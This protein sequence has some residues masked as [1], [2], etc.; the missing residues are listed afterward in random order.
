MGVSLF[1]SRVILGVLGIDDYGIYN[2][3]GGMVAMFS[4]FSTSLS[5]AISRFITFTIGK[6]ETWRLAAIFSTSIFIQL[7]LSIALA[8]ILET[9]G[10]YFFSERLNIPIDRMESAI[11]TFHCS[12]LIFILSIISVPYKATIIAYEKM[13]AFAYIGIVEVVMKLAI[14]YLLYIADYDKLKTYSILLVF[15]SIIILGINILY[16]K[17]HFSECKISRC[18][19][20]SIAKEMF[21]FAGW[22]IMGTSAYLI[23]TQGVNVLTNI[24]FGVTANAARGIANQVNAAVMQFVNSFTTAINPQITKSYA[25]GDLDYMFKLICKGAKLSFFM[26]Y[27]FTLPFMFE[28]EFILELWLKNYPSYAPLFLRLVLVDQMIDFLGNTTARAVWA[29][30]NVKKYYLK[31]SMISLLVL[32]ISYLM[33]YLGFSPEVPYYIFLTIYLIL[34]PVRLGVLNRLVRKFEPTFY[35]KQVIVPVLYV[36]VSS[37]ILPFVFYY[38]LNDGLWKHLLM[39][40]ISCFSVTFITYSL[41]LSMGEKIYIRKKIYSLIH[42]N[43]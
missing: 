6:G 34:I 4:F 36:S 10:F 8:L 3:V 35:Y 28:A 39:I 9:L 22:N 33:F 18:F 7:I 42:R 27:F 2:V 5:T 40:L 21:G 20:I 24:F 19:D 13:S 43:H 23:N 25:S 31:V 29:T 11:W 37:L 17:R 1:T 14:V 38:I 30:G 16:C 41:G 26:I 15:V 12:T 32:P